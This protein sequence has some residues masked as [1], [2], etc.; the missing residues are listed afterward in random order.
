MKTIGP[1]APQRTTSDILVKDNTAVSD[2]RGCRRDQIGLLV[3]L[4]MVDDIDQGDHVEA[5]FGPQFMSIAML[6]PNRGRRW[7]FRR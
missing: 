7:Q 4:D 5:S 1:S 3:G 6:K 2:V